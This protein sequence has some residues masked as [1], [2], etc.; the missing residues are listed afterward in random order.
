[1]PSEDAACQPRAVGRMISPAVSPSR[2]SSLRS[3]PPECASPSFVEKVSSVMIQ[4]NESRGASVLVLAF[5]LLLLL[6]LCCLCPTFD[7]SAKSQ[8]EATSACASSTSRLLKSFEGDLPCT[9]RSVFLSTFCL[10]A[11][12]TAGPTM[13]RRCKRSARA[14]RIH[15]ARTPS[16]APF[17]PLVT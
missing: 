2:T 1:M 9:C 13:M 5:M 16:C 14:T 10:P 3:Q 4:Q 11:F 12:R 8:R 6:L 17:P 7:D 15:F